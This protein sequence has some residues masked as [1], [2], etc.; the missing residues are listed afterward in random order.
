MFHTVADFIQLW[1]EESK[2]TQT[3]L[4]ALTDDSLNKKFSPDVRTIAQLSWHIIETP[5]EL[6]GLTGLKIA[7]SEDRAKGISNAKNLAAAHSDVA[8]SVAHQVQTHWNNK[9]LHQTDPMYGEVWTRSQSLLA[10]VNHM[11]HHR[12]QLT[13]LMRLAGLKVP[14]IYGPAKEEW[15]K[16]GMQPPEE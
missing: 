11:I 14:G 6:L 16:M 1:Q 13:V 10:L 8:R 7:G 5:H 12:G 4:E 2:H 3:I 15:V 9:S